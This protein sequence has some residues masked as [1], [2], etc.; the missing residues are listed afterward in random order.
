MQRTSKTR[1]T[2][3]RKAPCVQP[4]PAIFK[5]YDIRGIVPSTLNEEVALGLGRAFGTAARAE[6]QTTLAVGPA[7]KAIT[8]SSDVTRN[9]SPPER[10]TAMPRRERVCA[11]R[12]RC[13]DL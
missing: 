5:A 6:G 10:A 4:T 12:I 13:S 7:A 2:P 3:S 9:I 1:P 11:A 8:I